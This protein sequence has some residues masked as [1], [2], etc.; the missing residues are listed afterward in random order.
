MW[1]NSL[2][3]LLFLFG[4]KADL[5]SVLNSGAFNYS[6]TY[7]VHRSE[8]GTSSRLVELDS[9]L[10]PGIPLN[11]NMKIEFKPHWNDNSQFAPQVNCDETMATCLTFLNKLTKSI[12]TRN[13]TDI[14]KHFS[15]SF[16]FKGCLGIHYL[17]KIVSKLS[18]LSEGA[19]AVIENC[20]TYSNNH[21]LFNGTVYQ[22]MNKP[23]NAEFLLD[24]TTETLLEGRIVQCI[25]I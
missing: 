14:R 22:F 25:H 18:G 11:N 21:L 23:F 13:S 20:K 1:L 6:L 15:D 19:F 24:K 5:T 9:I 17:D 2:L 10:A 12:V 4:A 7:A 16:H 3:F 8:K